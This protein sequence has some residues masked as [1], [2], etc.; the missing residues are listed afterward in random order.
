[1][2]I[3]EA[4]F[5]KQVLSLFARMRIDDEKVRSWIVSV[6]RA[7]S[8]A[9]EQATANEREHLERELATIRQQRQRL[10]DL[11]LLDEIETATFTAKQTELRSK[12]TRLLT[13]LEGQG[14]QQSEKAGLAVKV[15]EL[16]QALT[17]KW[18]AADV[19]EK[20]LL[21]EIVCLNWTLDDVSLCP[22]TRKPFD[23]LAEGLLVSSSRSDGI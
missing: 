13:K 11:R 5:D 15:F 21:L 12:E 8:K 4:D 6:L 23:L 9:S 18:F 17:P 10:L 19:A 14:R 20:R 16:S 7:K 2:R 22:V 1:V 3:P